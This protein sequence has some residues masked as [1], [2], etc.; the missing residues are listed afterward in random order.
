MMD[1]SGQDVS[2]A[3]RTQY[4][5]LLK[6]QRA[7]LV[8]RG[9]SIRAPLRRGLIRFYFTHENAVVQRWTHLLGRSLSEREDW[10]GGKEEWGE[11]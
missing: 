5:T 2:V 6:T 3:K 1:A 11:F 7:P 4:S 8:S 10:E 9:V